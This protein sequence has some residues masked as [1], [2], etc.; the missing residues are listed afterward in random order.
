MVQERV[1]WRNAQKDG[2]DGEEGYDEM[3]TMRETHVSPLSYFSVLHSLVV[4]ALTGVPSNKCILS[5]S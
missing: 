1:Y 5:Q 4:M 3:G 2:M